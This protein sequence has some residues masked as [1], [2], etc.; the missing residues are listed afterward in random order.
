MRVLITV[1]SSPKQRL[2]V[3]LNKETAKAVKGLLGS[4]KRDKAIMTAITKGEFMGS[5]GDKEARSVD[6]DLI[7]T[8]HG[9]YWNL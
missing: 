1:E 2:L 5:I 4:R 9:A 7:L 6:V 8:K 3:E